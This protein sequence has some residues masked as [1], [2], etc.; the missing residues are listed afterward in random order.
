MKLVLAIIQTE[1]VPG[2]TRALAEA[3]IGSTRMDTAGGFLRESNATLLIGIEPE[4][5]P[6][7]RGLIKENCHIRIQL[8]D[9]RPPIMEP[10]EFYMP[11]PVEVQVGGATIFV[12]NVRQ[13]VHI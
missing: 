6:E 10:G 1:D 7:L 4:R 3:H 13:F 8:V 9:S 2:L 5:L 12:L 11:Y